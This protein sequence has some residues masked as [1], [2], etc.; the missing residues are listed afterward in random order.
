MD[1]KCEGINDVIG[2]DKFHGSGQTTTKE[3]I[4]VEVV[5]AIVVE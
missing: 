4:A 3:T 5:A 2:G 1:A